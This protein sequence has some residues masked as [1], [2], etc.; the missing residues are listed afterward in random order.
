MDAQEKE[1]SEDEKE[2]ENGIPFVKKSNLKN[3]RTA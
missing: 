2:K 1:L 3:N